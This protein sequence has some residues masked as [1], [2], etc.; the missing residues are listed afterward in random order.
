MLFWS[1]SKKLIILH[2]I[3]YEIR[4]FMILLRFDFGV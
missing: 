1:Y 2:M 4:K 3:Y